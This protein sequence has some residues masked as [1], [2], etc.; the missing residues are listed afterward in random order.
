MQEPWHCAVTVA[1]CWVQSPSP[2]RAPFPTSASSP[3][4][5]SLQAHS[6]KWDR[7]T[8]HNRVAKLGVWGGSWRQGWHNQCLRGKNPPGEGDSCLANCWEG[9]LAVT[10]EVGETQR[11]CLYHMAFPSTLGHSRAPPGLLAWTP[12]RTAPACIPIGHQCLFPLP[13]GSPHQRIPLSLPRAAVQ[14]AAHPSLGSQGCPELGAAQGE[15][16]V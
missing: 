6:A 12:G 4:R 15:R 1:C 8:R 10:V 13:F 3:A 14:N 9:T 11:L 5:Q 16:A 2:L 7:D